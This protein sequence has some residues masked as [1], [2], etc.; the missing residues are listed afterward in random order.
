MWLLVGRFGQ[1]RPTTTY[2]DE[3]VARAEIAGGANLGTR[4][5]ANAVEH[6]AWQSEWHIDA[7]RPVGFD[8]DRLLLVPSAAQGRTCQDTQG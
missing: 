4:Y 7:V 6:G 8:H 5:M 2:Q 3:L 1:V